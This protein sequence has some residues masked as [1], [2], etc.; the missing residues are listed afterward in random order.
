MKY[1]LLLG[2]TVALVA[3]VDVAAAKTPAEVKNIA[4]AVTVEIKLKDAGQS[5]HS[6]H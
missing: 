6:G 4:R 1:S 2:C 3:F 5:I